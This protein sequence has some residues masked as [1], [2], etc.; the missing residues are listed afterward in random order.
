MPI[1]SGTYHIPT[2]DECEKCHRGRSEHI[3]GFEQVELGLPGASGITLAD[4]VSQ[5]R[6]SVPPA[7]TALAIG[8]DG[9]GAAAPALGWLH[10]NCGI[11]CHNG[12][13]NAIAF[14][15]GLRFRLDPTQLDGRSSAGFDPLR[16]GVGVAV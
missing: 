16:T 9:T 3:L 2:G 6:L 4:L 1:G 5:G 13:T 12:N 10:A 8:D 14:P 11:T 15:S 7:T